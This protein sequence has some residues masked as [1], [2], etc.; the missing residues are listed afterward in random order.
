MLNSR[1]S[2]SPR[3]FGDLMADL[4]IAQKN[5]SQKERKKGRKSDPSSDEPK[6]RVTLQSFPRDKTVNEDIAKMIP[7]NDLHF[8]KSDVLSNT[9]NHL[10][11]RMLESNSKVMEE[12]AVQFIGKYHSRQ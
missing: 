5:V 2:S 12:D 8:E 3:T 1:K 11:K 6:K 9:P 7:A 4:P 10:D